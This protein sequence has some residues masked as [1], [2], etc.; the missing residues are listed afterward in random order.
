MKILVIGCGSIGRRHAANAAGLAEVAVF[1]AN[2]ALAQKCAQEIGARCFDKLADGLA[3]RPDGAVVAT[4]HHTH[5]AI[6][7]QAIDAGADVLIEKPLSH[8]STGVA[9]FLAAVKRSGKRVYVACNMRFHPGPSTL[10]KHL[11]GIGKPLFARAHVGNYLPAMRPDADYRQLYAAKRDQ[12]GGVVLDAIHEIDYLTWLFGPVR[13][14]NCRA[15]RISTLEIDTEDYAMLS[16]RH[17]GGMTSSAELDYLRRYKSRGC[18]IVGT[19]GTLLWQSD[20][21]QPERCLVRI[22]RQA[23]GA[24]ETLVDIADV[25]G[26]RPYVE[27]VREFMAA[28]QGGDGG[29]LLAAELAAQELRVALAALQSAAD[30][31]MELTVSDKD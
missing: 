2:A 5:L 13:S 27:Q 31:C 25:D 11:G 20:G 23:A 30:R 4:P 29:Q 14:V 1:D 26:G 18:E 24:W 17:G 10:R 19:D 21:K 8:S 3:W 15:D 7:Q 12:G 6:A 28:L 22:Y 9:A 16:L